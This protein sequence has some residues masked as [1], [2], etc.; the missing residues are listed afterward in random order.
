MAAYK[1]RLHERFDIWRRHIHELAQCENVVVKLGGLA[2]AFC[3]LP[4]DGPAA[5]HGSEHLAALWRPY[6]E[7]CIE[8]FGPRRAMFESNYPVDYWGADYAVLWN[9]FKRLTRSASADE[10]AALFAGTAARFYGIE[11]LLA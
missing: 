4:E 8:A 7:T 1:G 5:G 11:D 6:I 9:A 2:M 3:A 10:K